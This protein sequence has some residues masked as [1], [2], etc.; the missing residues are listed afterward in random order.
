MNLTSE[1]QTTLLALVRIHLDQLH[2]DLEF[3]KSLPEEVAKQN[4]VI[5]KGTADEIAMYKKI[6]WKLEAM[7]YGWSEDEEEEPDA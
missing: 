4:Q 2:A 3:Y 7:W 6:A 1:E 5:I